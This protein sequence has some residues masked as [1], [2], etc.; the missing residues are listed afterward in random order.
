VRRSPLT[1]ADFPESCLL[2]GFEGGSVFTAERDG[3]FYIIQ[4][5]STMA[6]FLSEEDL[7]DLADSLVKVLEFDTAA[8]REA[9]VRERGWAARAEG[10]RRY[11]GA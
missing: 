2:A 11:R 7:R 9:Y 4:D 1:R 5:E 3:K 10:Q 8:E 6:D